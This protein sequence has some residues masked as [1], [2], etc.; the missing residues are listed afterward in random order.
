MEKYA[1]LMQEVLEDFR[2][3]K[4]QLLLAKILAEKDDNNSLFIQ[5]QLDL[6]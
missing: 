1:N 3:K 6:Y 4:I 2:F 5:E